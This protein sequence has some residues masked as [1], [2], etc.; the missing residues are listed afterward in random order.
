MAKKILIACSNYF[1]HSFGGTEIY[2]ENYTKFLFKQGIESYIITATPQEYFTDE[3]TIY[4][5]GTIKVCKYIH[6][7]TIVFGL[8]YQKK[9]DTELIYS[10]HNPI[11]TDS[12]EHFISQ[13]KELASLD[14]LHINS[15]TATIGLNLFETIIK[16]N[17]GVKVI[18]SYHTPISCPKGT[19]VYKNTLTE[20]NISPDP[21]VCTDCLL[22]AQDQ[23]PYSITRYINKLNLSGKK[24]PSVFRSRYLVRLE[25]QSFQYLK[26]ITSEWWC[27]SE[28]IKNILKINDIQDSNIKMFRHGINEI[29]PQQNIEKSLD[30]TIYLF[31]GRL[32]KIKGI[33]TLL[34]AWLKTPLQERK[35][36][37]ITATPQS[38]NS[39][40]NNLVQQAVLRKDICFLGEKNQKDIAE[41]YAQA[42]VVVIPSECF[43]IGPLVFHEAIA[44]NCLV[45]AS[46]IG[47][48]KELSEFYAPQAE[49]FEA[50]NANE[51]AKVIQRGF[52]KIGSVRKS[53]SFKEHF[54]DMLAKSKIY[55]AL[56]VHHPLP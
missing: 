41:L 19:L 56:T 46:N 40:I 13:N 37:W 48:N 8:S 53:I 45:I 32:V 44:C 51:L 12:W 28:G 21:I 9:I 27:Y 22:R 50:G 1:P 36:L 18:T 42:H 52:T 3:N 2:V 10:K 24:I 25:I 11:Y 31:S 47:G 39:E 7:N 6:S 34:E 43:E 38:D 15:S 17:T 29:F 20:C 14:L 5:D 33:N 30:K 49:T 26:K 55:Q 4:V 23:L 35:Q 16:L 54:E